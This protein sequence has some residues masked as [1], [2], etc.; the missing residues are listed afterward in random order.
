MMEIMVFI[1]KKKVEGFVEPP[2]PNTV[3]HTTRSPKYLG[4]IL[5]AK[6]TWREHMKQR[7][8]KAYSSFWY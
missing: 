8:G 1:K 7:I 5:D 3:L 6:L 2:L 4:G